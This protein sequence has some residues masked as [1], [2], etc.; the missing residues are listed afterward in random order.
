[1]TTAVR[2]TLLVGYNKLHK[3]KYRKIFAKW[4]L[5]ST[6]FRKDADHSMEAF[7]LLFRRALSHILSERAK[8]LPTSNG[9]S[10]WRAISPRERETHK[11]ADKVLQGHLLGQMV[12]PVTHRSAL[13]PALGSILC[14]EID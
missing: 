7:L 4:H 1:M 12:A 5:Q 2:N 10:V 13:P 6:S 3:R 11:R 8:Q 9:L 14:S